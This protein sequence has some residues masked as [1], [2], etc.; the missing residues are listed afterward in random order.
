MCIRDSL[1]AMYIGVSGDLSAGKKMFADWLCKK[2]GYI[3][4]NLKDL[5]YTKIGKTDVNYYDPKYVEQRKEVF[6]K[7]SDDIVQNICAKHVIFPISTI[8]EVNAL[9]MYLS[10]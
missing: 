3:A 5:L 4:H 6:S 9:K 1:L 8:A 2:H 7:V 10:K